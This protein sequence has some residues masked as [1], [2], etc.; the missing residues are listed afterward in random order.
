MAVS[1]YFI[2]STTSFSISA[3]FVTLYTVTAQEPNAML[4]TRVTPIL[5]HNPIFLRT[6]TTGTSLPILAFVSRV[7]IGW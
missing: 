3:L 1:L 7:A 4:S 6:S 5:P 2:Q